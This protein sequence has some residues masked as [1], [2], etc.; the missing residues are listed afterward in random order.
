[1]VL[2]A[3]ELGLGAATSAA[4]LTLAIVKLKQLWDEVKDVPNEIASI[5]ENLEA[6][7]LM[8]QDLEARLRIDDIPPELRSR[9]VASPPQL[10]QRAYASL[11][12][13]IGSLN[14]ELQ[15]SN[16]SRRRF[17]S[18]KIV[19]QKSTLQLLEKKLQQAL[20]TFAWA[21]QI[22]QLVQGWEVSLRTYCLIPKWAPIFDDELHMVF[23]EDDFS[24][25]KRSLHT[26]GLPIWSQDM[27][28]LS[29]LA[30]DLDYWS[31][32]ICNL[33]MRQD[34]EL[35]SLELYDDYHG[36]RSSTPQTPFFTHLCAVL[37]AH[38]LD[39]T[40]GRAGELLA[41]ALLSWLRLVKYA[42][43]E[44][45]FLHMVDF[46]A[47]HHHIRFI[48]IDYGV[49]PEDWI[50]W[51]AIE[52]EELAGIFWNMVENPPLCLPGSWVEDDVLWQQDWWLGSAGDTFMWAGIFVEPQ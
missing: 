42:G 43:T 35:S 46:F 28:G 36:G 12:D 48:N 6:F 27:T 40:E 23:I 39:M 10:F 44:S 29:L 2:D 21:I 41:Q 31:E 5:L 11:Q 52:Y 33:L 50:L 45:H 37:E 15:K 26:H 19:L 30:P 7:G 34:T 8:L 18:I 51:W 16:G 1:M 49:E 24:A 14:M 38:Q 3:I 4:D 25:V 13:V 22:F 17:A 20:Q 32:T 47:R 9:I